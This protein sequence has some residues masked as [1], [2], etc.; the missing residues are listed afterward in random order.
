MKFCK[1]IIEN[2]ERVQDHGMD[3]LCR[4]HGLRS[5]SVRL[6]R[7]HLVT[8]FWPLSQAEDSKNLWWLD[9]GYSYV[10]YSLLYRTPSSGLQTSQPCSMQKIR[11]RALAILSLS[12][13]LMIHSFGTTLT[14]LIKGHVRLLIFRK[15]SSLPAVFKAYPFIKF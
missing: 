14:S 9:D 3:S 5:F 1:H 8:G 4:E 12:L 2:L 7:S 13:S 11:W 15:N 10:D 6:F